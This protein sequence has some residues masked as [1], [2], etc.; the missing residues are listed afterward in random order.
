M[1][2]DIGHSALQNAEAASTIQT[3]YPCPLITAGSMS[4]S[5]ICIINQWLL[6]ATSLPTL[7]PL[8]PFPLGYFQ[9]KTGLRTIPGSATKCTAQSLQDDVSPAIDKAS[10]TSN[11]HS[12]GFN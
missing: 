4:Q 11:E 7:S 10:L 5:G 12:E 8:T 9:C 3:D 6:F 1:K 2:I